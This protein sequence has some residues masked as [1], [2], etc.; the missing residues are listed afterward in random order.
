MVRIPVARFIAATTTLAG[1]V[2]K[3]AEACEPLWLHVPPFERRVFGDRIESIDE[4]VA[5]GQLF[6]V[7]TYLRQLHSM[8][9]PAGSGV[10][11]TGLMRSVLRAFAG[12][13]GDVIHCAELELHRIASIWTQLRRA[14]GGGV[15]GGPF[16]DGSN[17]PQ[18]VHYQRLHW[19]AVG[20]AQREMCALI[21]HPRLGVFLGEGLDPQQPP[22]VRTA[23]GRIAMALQ[24]H[25]DAEL[26]IPLAR[27]A[28]VGSG[29]ET[30][31]CIVQQPVS[32]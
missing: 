14:G 32:A 31:P 13:M 26:A 28:A 24:I 23:C 8:T 1:V 12:E 18:V 19:R 11:S 30:W 27:V 5:R 16:P 6:V 17:A 10:W 9:Q 15:A 7:M 22:A 20:A 4:L 2:H 21:E 3:I 29:I 25:L